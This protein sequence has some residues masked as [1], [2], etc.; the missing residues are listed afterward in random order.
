M[1]TRI[2]NQSASYFFALWRTLPGENKRLIYPVSVR[3][4]IITGC[5]IDVHFIRTETTRALLR[6]QDDFRQVL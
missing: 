4:N 1:N 5:I 3:T 2:L 6:N